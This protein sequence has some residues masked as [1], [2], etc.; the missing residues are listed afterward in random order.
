VKSHQLLDLPKKKGDY[1]RVQSSS[2]RV[3]E[4]LDHG[5]VIRQPSDLTGVAQGLNPFE[6]SKNPKRH[7]DI[8]SLGFG[9][10][11]FMRAEDRNLP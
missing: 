8:K 9:K 7:W 3:R 11:R 5:S 1:S 10:S 2:F 4:L 6:Q